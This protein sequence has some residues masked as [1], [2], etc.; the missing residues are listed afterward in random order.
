MLRRNKPQNRNEGFWR[1]NR[2]LVWKE[3]FLWTTTTTRIKHFET[4]PTRKLSVT[5]KTP[6]SPFPP[7]AYKTSQKGFVFQKFFVIFCNKIVT[8]TILFRIELHSR[9]VFILRQQSIKS[10]K[11]YLCCV[12]SW[13]KVPLTYER[14]R[15]PYR[16][17]R[18][19]IFVQ[20]IQHPP[21]N[22]AFVCI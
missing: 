5:M 6:L 14:T 13:S 9:S 4:H 10:K 19:W 1:W 7:S 8:L 2:I 20:Y 16:A 21:W 18:H 12:F 22:P 11:S 17:W 3:I 15:R